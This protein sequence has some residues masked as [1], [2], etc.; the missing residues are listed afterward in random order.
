MYADSN[1]I[2]NANLEPNLSGDM[3]IPL[4]KDYPV[5]SGLKLFEVDTQLQKVYAFMDTPAGNETL[6][7]FHMNRPKDVRTLVSNKDETYELIKTME[8]L[9]MDWITGTQLYW[10]KFEIFYYS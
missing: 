3:N 10:E 6:V 7:W 9:K 1:D 8:D 4:Q 2:K 5:L